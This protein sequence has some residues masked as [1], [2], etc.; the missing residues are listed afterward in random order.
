MG[1]P[2]WALQETWAKRVFLGHSFAIVAPTGIGKTTFGAVIAA[3]LEGKSYIVVPTK[4]LVSQITERL[5]AISDK[6]VVSYT[7]HKKDKEKIAAGEFDVLVTTHMFLYRNFELVRGVSFDFIFVDDVDSLL[8]SSRNVDYIFKLLGFSDEDIE[9]ALRYHPVNKKP[10]GVLVISSATATPRSR[11]IRLFQMILG[12]DVQRSFSSDIRNVTDAYITV[13]S[14]EEGLERLP[15]LVKRL[16]G[17][18]IVYLSMDLGHEWIERVK[19]KL[20]SIALSYEDKD[21]LERFR[22][23]EVEVLVGLSHPQNPLVR[24][25]DMP[26]RIR[27]AIFLGVPK[28]VFT[29]DAENIPPANLLKLVLML[30]AV[31]G[32]DEREK[33]EGFVALLSRC[34]AMSRRQ[35]ER[36]PIIKKRLEEI[37]GFVK[38]LLDDEGIIKRIQDSDEISLLFRDGKMEFIVGDA[39]SYIQASGR[40]SRLFAGGITKGLAV[41]L[42]YN[43]KAFKSLERRLRVSMNFDVEFQRFEDIE[44]E[45]ILE[46]IDR[47]RREVKEI[48]SGKTELKKRDLVKSSLV[49]VESPNKARTIAGFF[50]KPHRRVFNKKLMIY[51]VNLGNRV[52]SIV[53]SRGHVLDLVERA[54]IYGVVER[55]GE[56]VPVYSTIKICWDRS[57]VVDGD[58]GGPE[59]IS[60]DKQVIIEG[61]RELSMEAQEVFVATDP[62]S[63]GEKIAWDIACNL[64]P[65]NKNI[66]RSEFHEVT[67]SAF[68]RAIDDTRDIDEDMVKAQILRRIADRWVGFSL[69]QKLQEHFE[70][71]GL[72]AGRVQTPVLGWIIERENQRKKRVALIVLKLS[73]LEISFRIENREEAEKIFSRI[74]NADIKL[75]DAGVEELMPPPPLHTGEMLSFFSRSL[76]ASQTMDIAQELFEKGLITYHRTDSI[77]VSS[78]GLR[79]AKEYITDRFGEEY[80]RLRRWGEGGAHEC[81]RPTKPIDPDELRVMLKEGRVELT[82]Q[83]KALRLYEFI[84]KRFM[85][86]QMREAKAELTGLRVILFEKTLYEQKLITRLLEDGFNLMLPVKVVE[87]PGRLKIDEKRMEFVAPVAPYTQGTLIEEMRRRR[88]GRPSTYAKIVDTLLERH[89][90]IQKGRYLFPTSAGRV[91]YSYIVMRYP[92]FTSEEFTR[93]LEEMMDMVEARKADYQAILKD[94]KEALGL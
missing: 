13:S 81:I 94:L 58:C 23:G 61:L 53:A 66:H 20:G 92:E 55:S 12:F 28:I 82:D 75:E 32:Q 2:P 64:T 16:G 30:R 8:K 5:R 14:E 21:A 59:N 68:R 87:L 73:S 91:I 15:E 85:A 25:I 36:Y 86:S 31:A 52:I 60:L 38:K 56:F 49:I 11:K 83:A 46:Q 3:F 24:G 44:L 29:S 84:W 79:V 93:K 76:A 40:T 62:D 71:K 89:Y 74:D 78:A 37:E 27:Y 1:F 67:P 70:S 77:R 42:V 17:G 19:E 10:R 80:L 45:G 7:G 57:Q 54:G 9:E 26:E 39:A 18:G 69:S 6:R 88:I 63:E 34:R 43:R 90:V 41:S 47:H 35:I 65:F 50:G 4:A 33:L 72:S 22:S 51:E 48:L